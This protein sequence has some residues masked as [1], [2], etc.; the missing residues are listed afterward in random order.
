[1]NVTNSLIILSTCSLVTS[2]FV[3]EVKKFL[4]E[5]KIKY[6]CNVL[7]LFVAII[8]G[9]GVTAL[10]YISRQIPFD[11]LNIVY[12]ILMGI[13]NWLGAMIGYDK[14]KQMIMQINTERTD[15]ES[16]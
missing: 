5:Q 2:L 4:N 15:N 3:Q 9:C 8:I 6:S 12:L 7:V 14:V 11:T 16:K 13:A 10:Y 1:M